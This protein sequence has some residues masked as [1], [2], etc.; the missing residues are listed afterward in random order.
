[1]RATVAAALLVASV[2]DRLRGANTDLLL[3]TAPFVAGHRKNT[4]RNSASKRTP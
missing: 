4:V 2:Q 3:L 1:M